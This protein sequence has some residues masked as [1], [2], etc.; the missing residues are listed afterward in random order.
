MKGHQD[1]E[2]DNLNTI[3]MMNCKA[4]EL[5]KAGSMTMDR[6]IRD[7]YILPG[8]KWQLDVGHTK[9]HRNIEESIPEYVDRPTIQI[10]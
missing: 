5:S 4:D 7:D 9:V 1:K 6:L 10:F 3:E 2:K 8:E